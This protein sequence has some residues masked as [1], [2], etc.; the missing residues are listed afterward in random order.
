MYLQ[1]FSGCY[2]SPAARR[3]N[4]CSTAREDGPSEREGP[5]AKTR[6]EVLVENDLLP[7]TC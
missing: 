7:P 1:F 5:Q 6:P 4:P 3:E 2:Y